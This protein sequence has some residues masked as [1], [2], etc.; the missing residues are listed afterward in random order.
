MTADREEHVDGLG[1]AAS[2]PVADAETIKACCA[3]VYQS[4]WA[5]LLLGESFH[6]GGMALTERLGHALDLKPGTRVLDIA[7]GRGASA[8]H[9]AKMFGCAVV[10]VDLGPQSVRQANVAAESSGMGQLVRFI[11]G[12]AERLP[13]EGATF[14][15]VICECAFCT[16]PDKS[17]A[18]REITRALKPGGYVGISD[19]TR[20]GES[21]EDLR[22]LLAWIA[23]IA[24]ARPVTEYERILSGAGLVIEIVEPH[25]EVLAEYVRNIQARLLGAELMIGLKRLELPEV[26]FDE[27]KALARA[28]AR[29]VRMGRFGYAVLVASK[30]C[31][32]AKPTLRVPLPL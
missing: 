13:V 28:A 1:E 21:P 26:N 14:D 10:G 8:I 9:L 2:S 5:R 6:P 18:A 27:A 25:D 31:N 32:P 29:A 4:D 16:F 20:N 17:T 24:D 23:C 30:P 7:A 12:D 22:S 11:R 15:V 3:A 19:L